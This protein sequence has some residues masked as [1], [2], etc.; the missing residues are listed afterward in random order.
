MG[1]GQLCTAPHSLVPLELASRPPPAPGWCWVLGL[2]LPSAIGDPPS[3]PHSLV[4]IPGP[5]APARLRGDVLASSPGTPFICLVPRACPH[6]VPGSSQRGGCR[7]SWRVSHRP[8]WPI[9]A[10]W[11]R[12]SVLASSLTS[13]RTSFLKHQPRWKPT[14]PLG[15][16]GAAPTSSGHGAQPP[17]WSGCLIPPSLSL[18]HQRLTET[19]TPV[20][21]LR[22][23][24][25]LSCMYP[26][27]KPWRQEVRCSCLQEALLVPSAASLLAVC[28][29]RALSLPLTWCTGVA[30]CDPVSTMGAP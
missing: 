28:P 7:G 19:P 12:S 24:P 30:T 13:T 29:S 10:A 9:P 1:P 14:G 16:Q 21:M 6:L 26:S 15:V 20:L 2:P 18:R 22:P 23:L 3:P 17:P 4:H 27:P 11:R 8:C 25:G 5:G